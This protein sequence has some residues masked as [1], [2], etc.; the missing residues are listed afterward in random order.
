M[1]DRKI[2]DDDIEKIKVLLHKHLPLQATNLEAFVYAEKVTKDIF[3]LV[4]RNGIDIQGVL[5][6]ALAKWNGEAIAQIYA[7][8]CTNGPANGL[9]ILK[10]WAKE[11]G[12]KKILAFTRRNPRAFE[13]KFG[14]KCLSH[15][16]GL[17]V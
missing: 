11:R 7:T 13:R 15:V 16:I 17:E 10:A 6:A 9:D 1:L 2:T 3:I 12:A 5:I 14:F 8:I 4:D